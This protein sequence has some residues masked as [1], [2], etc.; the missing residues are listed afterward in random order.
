M[1]RM[2]DELCRRLFRRGL[3]GGGEKGG[4]NLIKS[5]GEMHESR[6]AKPGRGMAV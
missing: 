4:E 1:T 5:E 2:Y 3:H 6:D